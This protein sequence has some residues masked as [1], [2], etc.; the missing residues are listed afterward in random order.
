M[1]NFLGQSPRR[2]PA[3]NAFRPCAA[4]AGMG[5]LQR[6]DFA[7]RAFVQCKACEG[8]GQVYLEPVGGKKNGP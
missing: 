4:C 2:A 8:L 1:T 3:N 5:F 6:G 7:N